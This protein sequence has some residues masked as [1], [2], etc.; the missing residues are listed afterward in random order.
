MHSARVIRTKEQSALAPVLD[1]IYQAYKILLAAV[2]LA[3]EA[4]ILP[5]RGLARNLDDL[6]DPTIRLLFVALGLFFI[7]FIA[8]I[9]TLVYR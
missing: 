6:F 1:L 5:L 4:L 9:L 7:F 3:G 2:A 8:L